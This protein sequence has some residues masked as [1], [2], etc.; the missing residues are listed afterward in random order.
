MDPYEKITDIYIYCLS[1][2]MLQLL[3]VEEYQGNQY[4]TD[5]ER[6]RCGIGSHD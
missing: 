5:S 2:K 4:A 1:L 6:I 3:E